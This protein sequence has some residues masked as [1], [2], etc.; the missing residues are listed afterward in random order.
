MSGLALRPSLDSNKDKVGP[1]RQYISVFD[2][3]ISR[4]IYVS[5]GWTQ[6]RFWYWLR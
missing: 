5:R 1:L 2:L 3:K 4:A 6:T